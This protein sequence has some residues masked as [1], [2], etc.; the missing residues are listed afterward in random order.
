MRAKALASVLLIVAPA[1]AANGQWALATSTLGLSE[2]TSHGAKGRG[3][4]SNGQ[5]AFRVEALVKSFASGDPDR[6]AQIILTTRAVHFPVMTL[7]MSMPDAAGAAAG[8][9]CD[10]D[11]EFAGR[12]AKYARVPF[13][14][15]M[16]GVGMRITGTIP[17]TLRDFKIDSTPVL[18]NELPLRV[19]VTWR[20]DY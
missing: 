18:R 7:R 13:Q 12:T 20:P 19:D 1:V 11:V 14:V 16:T 15:S 8:F 2:S 5:C 3:T 17:A 4:C 9:T 6:D 10:V